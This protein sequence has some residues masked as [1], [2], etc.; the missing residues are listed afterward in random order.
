V[1]G[2][3]KF[4]PL[5]QIQGAGVK[6]FDPEFDYHIKSFI[7]SASQPTLYFVRTV[8]LF[9]QLGSHS[10]SYNAVADAQLMWTQSTTFNTCNIVFNMQLIPPPA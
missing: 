7:T 3:S 2:S 8:I 10:M 9:L 4:L 5:Y 6:G 1:H